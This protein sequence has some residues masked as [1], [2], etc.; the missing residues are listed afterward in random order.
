MDSE[1]P[2][3]SSH[4]GAQAATDFDG[5]TKTYF[6]AAREATKGGPPRRASKLDAVPPQKSAEASG[7]VMST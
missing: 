5:A 4:R 2:L 3:F 7:T 6:I 1:W